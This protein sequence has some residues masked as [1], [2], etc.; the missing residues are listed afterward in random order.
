MK[1]SAEC[2]ACVAAHAYNVIKKSGIK[3]E[4]EFFNYYK[5]ILSYTLQKTSWGDKPIE[6]LKYVYDYLEEIFGDKDFYENEKTNSNQMLIEMYDDLYEYSRSSEDPIYAALKLS[7]VA[8]L[9]DYGVKNSFGELEFEIESLSKNR[10]FTID[11]YELFTKKLE[12]TETLLFIHDNAGEIVLDKVL[13]KIIKDNYPNIVIY[14]AL[15]SSPVINDATL[16]DAEEIYLKEVSIPIESGSKY[17]GTLL[18]SVGTSFMSIYNKANLVI[19]KG[20]GNFEGLEGSSD[21]VFFILMAKCKT[22]ASYL[23][24]QVGDIIFKKD[25]LK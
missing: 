12:T 24:I 22:I 25:S 3:S 5:K 10:E 2:L 17:P 11:D 4:E 18:E 8:N 16:R 6:I 14:S 21:K 15:R 7:A 19:S 1:A 9:I 20:Q 13:I 23:N